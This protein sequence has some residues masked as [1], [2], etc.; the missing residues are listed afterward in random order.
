MKFPF[1]TALTYFVNSRP[2]LDKCNYRD[3]SAYRSEMRRITKQRALAFEL[4]RKVELS[5]ITA[6][7]LIKA[8]NTAFSGRLSII[9]DG[10]K[11]TIDYCTGQ[12]YP[13]EYR[14]A[15]CHVLKTALI[16]HWADTSEGWDYKLA[17]RSAK[18]SFS[19]SLYRA[20]FA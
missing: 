3:V 5:S 17:Q 9:V 16:N 13:T 11:V 2:S 6:E 14:L 12:Y 8:A 10:E 7:S 4:I 18:H 20:F 19:P 1:L 15:V